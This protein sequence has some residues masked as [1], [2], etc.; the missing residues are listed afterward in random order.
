M[1][2]KEISR[3]ARIQ[4]W[5]III[6][7]SGIAL[8]LVI[9][10]A[11]LNQF[12]ER[13]ELV[14]SMLID[15]NLT[16]SHKRE[17]EEVE[18]GISEAEEVLKAIAAVYRESD[19]SPEYQWSQAYLDAVDKLDSIREI[20]YFPVEVMEQLAGEA[21]EEQDLAHKLING[22]TVVSDVSL[23]ERPG[24][25]AVFGVAVPVFQ[26][27]KVIGGLRGILR[28]D[29]LLG[30]SGSYR[31]N[32]TDN[33]LVYRNGDIILDA[34][35]YYGGQENL[36]DLLKENDISV[37]EITKVKGILQTR[38]RF[39]VIDLAGQNSAGAAEGYMMATDLGYND[40]VLISR[41]RTSEVEDYANFVMENTEKLIQDMLFFMVLVLGLAWA[42]YENR[43]R[44]IMRGQA[45]YDL[46]AKFSD[47]V[48]FQYNCRTRTM[49]FT[50]NI[51]A[52]FN[53]AKIDVIYPFNQDDLTEIIHPDDIES[54]REMLHTAEKMGLSQ[55]ISIT[56][57]FMDR[58]YKY[59][60]VRCSGHLIQEK[61]N[62]PLLL[63]GKLADVQE[64]K[65]KEAQLL[66]QAS[67]DALTGAWNRAAVQVKIAKELEIAR[68]GFLFMLDVDNFKIINDSLGHAVG[69]RILEDF[70]N[71][72]KK[73]FRR[74]DIV[75]R[76]GGDEF[77]VFMPGSDDRD[78]VEERAD[79]LLKQLAEWEVP[80]T[81]SIGIARFPVDGQTY[82]ELCRAAD[83]AM[84]QAKHMGKG[85]CFFAEDM[86]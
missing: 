3:S 86:M 85:R 56:V 16:L 61:A 21:G 39:K 10:A 71:E 18:Q 31:Y 67:M 55:E 82:G 38:G 53:M 48:L 77:V 63:V 49:V 12:H 44:R 24:Y 1:D 20:R 70:V 28:A 4:R 72:M 14:F 29:T 51:A 15:E 45:Q 64:E 22:E 42:L 8:M 59:R 46:L 2:H 75:G 69:D 41:F 76:I 83:G 80:I 11:L 30:S 58:D 19:Q 26:G 25:G 66:K 84:Y 57:R 78:I 36:L 74:E 81:V 60:W 32:H 34:E 68:A 62:G 40:W 35:H 9:V 7:A 6:L 54:L 27:G 17:V 52:R 79:K 37:Q 23:S 50:P 47:T 5:G 13:N 65:S 33:C 43:R 73:F